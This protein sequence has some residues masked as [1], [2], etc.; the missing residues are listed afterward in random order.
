MEPNLQSPDERAYSRYNQYGDNPMAPVGPI[1]L[2]PLKG[3]V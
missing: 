3:S 1:A 2:V